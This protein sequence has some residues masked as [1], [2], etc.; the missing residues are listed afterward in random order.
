MC[1]QYSGL[2]TDLKSFGLIGRSIDEIY[3][4]GKLYLKLRHFFNWLGSRLSKILILYL[5]TFFGAKL[6]D[7]NDFHYLLIF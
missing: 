3:K 5:Q 1:L 2:F 7:P 4:F 6:D